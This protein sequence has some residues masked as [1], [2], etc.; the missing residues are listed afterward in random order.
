MSLDNELIYVDC[1]SCGLGHTLDED[2]RYEC[3]EEGVEDDEDLTLHGD[4][5]EMCGWP[6]PYHGEDE[7]DE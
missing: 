5:C 6:E 7:D 2:G 3:P 1:Y 4:G